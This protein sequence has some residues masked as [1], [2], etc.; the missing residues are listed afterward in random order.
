MTA[1]N[2]PPPRVVIVAENASAKFGGEAIL[3]VHYFRLLRSRG[4]EAWLVTHGRTRDELEEAF[5]RD[6]DR[7]YF[8]PDDR[9]HRVLWRLGSVLP[10]SINLVTFTALSHLYTALLARRIVRRVIAEQKANLVHQPIPVSPREPS[11]MH[12]LGVPVVIGPMNGN[13]DWPKGFDHHDSWVT[14]VALAFVRLFASLF[15]VLI[16]GKRRAAALLV[17]NERTRDALPGS[18]RKRVVTFPENGVDLRVWR[19]EPPKHD[20]HQVAKFVFLGRLEVFKGVDYALRALAIARQRANIML[21]IVGDGE[22]RPR[23]EALIDELK[24]RD[25]VNMA[26]WM[27]QA[28][29]ADRLAEADVMVMPSLRDCGGAVV[30]EA[31]A[32]ALPVI[33]TAWGGPL[34]YLDHTCGVLVPPTDPDG[35]V[36]GLAD[37]MVRM[38]TDPKLRDQ[39]GQAGRRRVLAEFDW[40]RKIDYMLKVYQAVLAGQPVPT[41]TVAPAQPTVAAASVP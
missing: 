37:A 35:F 24:L 9:V 14:H 31:M 16:P 19:P 1:P 41:F 34:D 38:A 27:T 23:I 32:S 6:R 25:R 4:Y 15:Q 2:N 18:L 21:E 36:R 39:M 7:M 40:E 5:P 13:M 11:V 8:V 22:M 28:E 33:S 26:G 30:L 17:A 20:V 10:H 29:A 3:P 12:G